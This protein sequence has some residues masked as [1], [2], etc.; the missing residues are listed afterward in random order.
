MRTS[1]GSLRF[2]LASTALAATTVFSG[3]VSTTF[4]S[5]TES[6]V[7][8]ARSSKIQLPEFDPTKA[9]ICKTNGKTSLSNV[10]VLDR[11]GYPRNYGDEGEPAVNSSDL[12]G[13]TSGLV[14][15]LERHGKGKAVVLEFGAH[16]CGPCYAVSARLAGLEKRF[17]NELLIISLNVISADADLRTEIK[18]YASSGLSIAGSTV[19]LLPEKS[20]GGL[21]AS[22][23]DLR[24]GSNLPITII[25]DKNGDIIFSHQGTLSMSDVL[26]KIGAALAAP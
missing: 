23:S 4:S 14:N 19:L 2:L 9:I 6:T 26:P 18:K 8:T 21:V 3:C 16:W 1:F 5:K 7:E 24:R 11:D 10:L 15:Y 22:L 13:L 17:G 25:L 12:S 20:L